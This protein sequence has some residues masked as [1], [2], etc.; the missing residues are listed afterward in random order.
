MRWIAGAG[1]AL[2]VSGGS[3]L[4]LKLLAMIVSWSSAVDH[5]R[6]VAPDVDTIDLTYWPVLLRGGVPVLVVAGTVLV[7]GLVLMRGRTR[8][9]RVEDVLV[10]GVVGGLVLFVGLWVGTHTVTYVLFPQ[11]AV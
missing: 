7:A 10:G 1:L 8:S 9:L 2:T 6:A 3:M 5:V 11:I 4:V